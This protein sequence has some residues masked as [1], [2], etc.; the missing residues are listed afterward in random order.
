MRVD[1]GFEASPE[2]LETVEI[3]ENRGRKVRFWSP[4]EIWTQWLV[5]IDYEN[6][7][8]AVV[9]NGLDP[10]EAFWRAYERLGFSQLAS[11]A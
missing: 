11:L 5:S 8:V 4:G 3:L 7:I 2:L 1:L 9:E 10:E 6:A